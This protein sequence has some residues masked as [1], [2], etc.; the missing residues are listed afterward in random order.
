MEFARYLDT[1]EYSFWSGRSFERLHHL[2]VE[3]RLYKATEAFKQV[4]VDRHRP[5]GILG[6]KELKASLLEVKTMGEEKE[7][8]CR[9]S[10]V[11]QEFKLLSSFIF[12]GGVELETNIVF[13]GANIPC[14]I[15]SRKVKTPW[16]RYDFGL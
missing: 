2:V 16:D 4:D 5:L 13:P 15:L 12:T 11:L 10:C 9:V 14:V 7:L 3:I 8:C 1:K 6:F